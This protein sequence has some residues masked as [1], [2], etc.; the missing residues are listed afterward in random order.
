[1]R[2]A[3]WREGLESAVLTGVTGS[4]PEHHLR[5]AKDGKSGIIPDAC[6]LTLCKHLLKI[7]QHME[8]VLG[9]LSK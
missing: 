1:M 8:K 4:S 2:K 3:Q 6:S 5:I 7:K 9:I